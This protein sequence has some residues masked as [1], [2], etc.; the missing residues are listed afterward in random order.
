MLIRKTS[1]LYPLDVHVRLEWQISLL[2][3]I[4]QLRNPYPSGIP[5]DG[6]SGHDGRDRNRAEECITLLNCQQYLTGP[7]AM[8]DI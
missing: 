8:F 5:V 6:Q 1:I 7:N 2:F 3:H 4:L